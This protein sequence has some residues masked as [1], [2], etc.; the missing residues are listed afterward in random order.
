VFGKVAVDVA[1]DG[2]AFN[3]GVEDEGVGHGFAFY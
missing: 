3:V 2:A 1:V